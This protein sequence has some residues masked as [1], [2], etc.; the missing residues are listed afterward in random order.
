MSTSLTEHHDV[1]VIGSGF[2]G[3]VVAT[4]LVEAGAR[5]TL[6]ERG[7]W[8]D[9]APVRAAGVADPSPLPTRWGSV[10]HLVRNVSSGTGPVRAARLDA[11][12]LYDVHYDRDLSVVCSS[13]V[14]GG[15]HVYTA[16]L[17]RPARND[18]WDGHDDR[19]TPA[20]MEEHYAWFGERFASRPVRPADGVPSWPPVHPEDRDLFDQHGV[21][22]PAMAY[23]FGVGSYRNNTFTGS[24]D[25]AKR[26]LDTELV[27]PAME[28]G[29]T[30]RSLHEVLE[31]STGPRGYRLTV[32]DHGRGR[33]L[34][35]E[36]RQVVLAAGA[37]NTLRLLLGSRASGGLD[38][39]PSLGHHLGGNG[40]HMA[41]WLQH[42]DGV[43][44]TAGTPSH[45]RVRPLGWGEE[46]F[47]MRLGLN[48]ADDLRL[49]RRV[50]AFLRGNP[51]LVGMGR[52][53]ATGAAE[54]HRG[55]LRIR[56]DHAANPVLALMADTC[57]ELAR[58]SRR[59]V[60][61][62]PRG[63]GLTVHLHGGARVG[64][65]AGRGVVD[66]RGQVHGHP[67]LYV[68]DAAALPGAV[69][70]PP[71]LTIAAWASHVGAE[72]AAQRVSTSTP[73]ARSPH[74]TTKTAWSAR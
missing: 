63:R 8:R 16:M 43:D 66:W 25:G 17:T 28:R 37:L 32:R 29:L 15:S 61:Q 62:L 41:W 50:R 27:V 35:L 46:P 68:A 22:Q 57:D 13:G 53:R 26:T 7:P 56:Y 34:T 71:S 24:A 73:V 20:G 31:V 64:A 12:G 21:E 4:R 14:G 67:G 10:R 45:G 54:W 1:I 5:V 70:T 72:L 49:P 69:G 6:L 40:D 55:R 23:R 38:G 33:L 58:A 42:R 9:T 11:R 60:L 59:R 65:D 48:G 18:Y 52:D 3:A 47:M 39:M 36:A 19:V 30:V 74:S 51:L 44:Y 2:G